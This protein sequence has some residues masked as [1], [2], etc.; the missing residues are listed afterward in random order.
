MQPDQPCVGTTESLQ[1][2]PSSSVAVAPSSLDAR[3]QRVLDLIHRELNRDFSVPELARTTGLSDSY[4][5]HLF[6]RE[7]KISPGKYMETCRLREAERLIRTTGCSIK[8]ICALVGIKDRSHFI[9]NFK[10]AYSQ[11]PSRYRSN[12]K[13]SGAAAGR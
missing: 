8:D 3:V 2:E 6:R 12:A 1:I 10:R 7:M 9:R 11:S 5:Y 4:F 13:A